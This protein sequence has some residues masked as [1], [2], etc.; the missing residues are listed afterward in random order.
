[1]QLPR[2]LPVGARLRPAQAS[3]AKVANDCN[4]PPGV[5]TRGYQEHDRRTP[6][7][8]GL[9]VVAQEV[10]LLAEQTAKTTS[11]IG[12][13]IREGQE[14]T[15]NAVSSITS[16]NDIVRS[17][18]DSTL[19]IAHS[20]ASRETDRASGLVLSFSDAMSDEAEQLRTEAEFLPPRH[21]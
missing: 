11:E 18:N 16:I 10:K 4:L 1:M 14:L 8:C 6:S 2:P 5:L 13:Q 7:L 3:A 15:D 19:I 17:I 12:G 20:D 9:A 21:S